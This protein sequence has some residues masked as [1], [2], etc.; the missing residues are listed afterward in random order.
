MSKEGR[1]CTRLNGIEGVLVV[2]FRDI[3]AASEIDSERRVPD[4]VDSMVTPATRRVLMCK[5]FTVAEIQHALHQQHPTKAPSQ[6]GMA[7]L[8]YQEVMAIADAQYAFD[9]LNG[10]RTQECDGL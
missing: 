1:W 9:F 3:F 10:E 8:F 7:A 6:D 2:Y 4:S 5:W